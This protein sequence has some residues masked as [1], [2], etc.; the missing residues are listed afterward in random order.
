MDSNTWE[1]N[2]GK[3]WLGVAIGAAVGIGIALSRRRSRGPWESARDLT[4]RVADRSNDLADNARDLVDRVRT[5]Y[6]QGVKVVEDAAELW[7][8]GRKMVGI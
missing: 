4:R 5:I 7:S 6:E 2:S 3:I 8:H 1:N